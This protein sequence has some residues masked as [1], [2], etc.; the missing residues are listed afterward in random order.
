MTLIVAVAMASVGQV[1]LQGALVALGI[2]AA[3][4]LIALIMAGYGLRRIWNDTG[5]GAF[6]AVLAGLWA[7][8]VLVSVGLLTFVVTQTPSYPDIATNVNNPPDYSAFSPTDGSRLPLDSASPADRIRISLANPDLE[9]QFVERP[10]W[11]VA[12][13]IGALVLA[14]GWEEARI[15]T[16]SSQTNELEFSVPG[17]LP[18]VNHSIA[19]RVV[20]NGEGALI[21][22]RSLSNIPLHD[23]GTNAPVL[24]GVLEQIMLAI[25]ATPPPASDL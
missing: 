19:I 13:V 7:L 8:P 17:S 22:A 16:V 12:E 2:S 23:F 21:D 14:N 20:D 3:L 1:P 25:E 15:E 9:T 24:Q 18:L 4:A 10:G 5:S 6:D 11:H